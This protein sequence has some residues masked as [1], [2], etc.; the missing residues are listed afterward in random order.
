MFY[1]PTYED[2]SRPIQGPINPW[3]ERKLEKMNTITGESRLTS[4]VN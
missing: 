2:M 1:N 3:N 4:R